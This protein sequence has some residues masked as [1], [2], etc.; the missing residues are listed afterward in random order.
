MCRGYFVYLQS[1]Q[2]QGGGDV[3]G[4][5]AGSIP[6]WGRYH[7][8]AFVNW[9]VKFLADALL[10]LRKHDL[11]V[12]RQQEVFV[13]QCFRLQADSGHWA[14]H[15]Q[16]L[17][18][19]DHKILDW[20]E[21]ALTCHLGATSRP[22]ILDLGCGSVRS[23]D[24]LRQRHPDW[25]LL[26]IDPSAPAGRNDLRAGSACEIPYPD[27]SFDAVYTYITLQHVADLA[28]ALAEIRRVLKSGGIFVVCD[29]SPISGRGA[30]KPWHEIRGRWI[31]SWDSPFRERWHTAGAWRRAL[32]TA[33]FHP[34]SSAGLN[35]PT[36][37]GLRRVIPAN[38]FVLLSARS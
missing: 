23:L 16:S 36:D 22:A 12:W 30:L 21:A 13:R 25:Q 11:P 14:Q 33:G 20:T 8:M 5:L 35:S 31:Y 28:R 37:K 1:K 26:G 34:I 9:G 27:G 24:W 7:S 15:S 17:D 38:R 3:C 6:L 18:V 10:L 32:K 29:R 2:C 19:V 4:G